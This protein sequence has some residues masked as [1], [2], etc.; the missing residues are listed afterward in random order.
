MQTPIHIIASFSHANTQ[1]WHAIDLFLAHQKSNQVMLWSTDSANI[2]FLQYPIQSI[3][4]YTGAAPNAGTLVIVGANTHIGQWYKSAR[5]KRVIL[6]HNQLAPAMLY[7][8]LHRLTQLPTLQPVKQ[9]EI[10]YLT[11]KIKQYCG[12]PGKVESYLPRLP[13]M[14]DKNKINLSP[15]TVGK[16]TQNIISQ[17]HH[18]D[19]GLYEALAAHN[20]HI[21]LMGGMC[22]IKH[23]PKSLQQ[24]PCLTFTDALNTSDHQKIRFFQ[25]IH[26][27]FHRSPALFNESYSL[28]TLQAMQHG[29]P[30]VCHKDIAASEHIEH[31]VNGFI[32]STQNEALEILLTLKNNANLR[33]KVGMHAELMTRQ[34][35]LS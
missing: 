35:K 16:I 5:F 19:I 4:S 18:A 23:L 17:H 26:C 34:L 22:L 29:L 2:A 10:I 21:N 24:S 33:K 3:K 28:D 32:F 8:A 15:F 25:N 9:I 1:A 13:E 31:G 12:L 20:V 14:S 30:V 27:L 6:H 11:E 7:Q